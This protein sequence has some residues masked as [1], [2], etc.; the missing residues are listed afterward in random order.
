VWYRTS[1]F[2]ASS[3]PIVSPATT[4]ISRQQEVVSRKSDGSRISRQHHQ[5][6]S[7]HREMVSKPTYR[8]N[9]YNRY[10]SYSTS[11]LRQQSVAREEYL[12]V[13]KKR[14]FTDC[15]RVQLRLVKL[16]TDPPGREGVQM[17]KNNS[18]YKSEISVI[19]E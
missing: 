18:V 6:S 1:D 3:L 9:K 13:T 5:S 16:S 4:R 8:Y 17:H 14:P 15:A 7:K 10:N 19:D 11:C 2:I 12:Y